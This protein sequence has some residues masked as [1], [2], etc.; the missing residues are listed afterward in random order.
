MIEHGVDAGNHEAGDMGDAVEDEVAIGSDQAGDVHVLVV[1]A[2]VIAFSDEALNDLDH[3]AFPQIISTR[4]EAESEDADTAVF[5]LHDEPK[6]FAD[7]ELVA[8]QNGANNGQLQVM[9]LG[10]VGES[11]QIL[12][13]AGAAE[14]EAR[15]QVSG[16]D[17]EFAVLAEDVH[18]S[19]GVNAEGLT[20]VSDF[21]GEADFER[22]PVVVDIFDH[23]GGLEVGAD[24][25]GLEVGVEGG[26]RVSAGLVELADD[27]FGRRIE[28]SNGRTFAQ[29]FR[30]MADAEVHTGALAGVFLKDRNHDIVHG[31][32]EDGTADDHCVPCGFI[33]EC[34]ADLLADAA[35]VAEV[36]VAVGL[37]GCADAH[38]R[39]L[40]LADSLGGV[41][42]GAQTAGS[43]T[44]FDQ[45]SDLGF[46]DRGQPLVDQIDFGLHRI[47]AGDGVAVLGQAACRYGADVT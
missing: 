8:W 26:E 15:E 11:A 23:L 5:L 30:V 43:N 44:G 16:G 39:Q 14:G 32:W 9:D 24:E 47:N 12:G 37:A 2:Q 28:I 34:L 17:V 29:E 33:L 19:M 45:F 46:D 40:R 38:E 25:W 21:V 1:N 13:E 20:Q 10:L 22:M 6:A 3:G 18:D 36:K 35:D 41:I 7:L 4:L 31:A 27:G 42:G